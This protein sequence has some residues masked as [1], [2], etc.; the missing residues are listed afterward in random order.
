MKLLHYSTAPFEFDPA[1]KY[2]GR[3]GRS[4]KPAGLWISVEGASDWP[5]WCEEEKFHLE[6]LKH[7]SEITL[8][9]EANVLVINSAEMLDEFNTKYGLEDRFEIR[10][11]SWDS[12]KAGHDGIIIAPYQYARRLDLMWYYTW[13]CASGV[14]WNLSA[15]ANVTAYRSN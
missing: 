1:M 4:D 9:P 2:N 7:I 10:S 13:D 14:I 11:I 8:A 5:E 3:E 6:S 12:V 15:V